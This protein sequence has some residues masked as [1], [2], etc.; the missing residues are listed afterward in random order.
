M[1]HQPRGQFVLLGRSLREH[2]RCGL[3]QLL[4]AVRTHAR[5]RLRDAQRRGPEQLRHVR[6]RLRDWRGLLRRYLHGAEHDHALRRLHDHLRL[7]S[8]LLQRR[9]LHARPE[10]VRHQQ[11]AVLPG[12]PRERR[13]WWDGELWNQLPEWP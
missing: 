5:R 11:C 10:P 4:D 2:V 6:A 13:L 3:Q 9:L 1:Q 7:G 12:Y 8:G